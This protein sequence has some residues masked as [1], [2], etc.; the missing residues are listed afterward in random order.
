MT[1]A[2]EVSQVREHQATMKADLHWMKKE[3]T[4]QNK[5]LDNIEKSLHA[6]IECA[7]DKY[8]SK[9]KLDEIENKTNNINLILA[10][11]GGALSFIIVIVTVVINIIF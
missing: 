1:I 5:K 4:E 10:K 8:A 9:K 2:N 3:Q 6:F 7:D 11:W